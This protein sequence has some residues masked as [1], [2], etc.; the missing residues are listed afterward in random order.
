MQCYSLERFC[1]LN[2]PRLDVRSQAVADN[3]S[4]V[5]ELN[6]ATAIVFAKA[7]LKRRLDL[8]LLG[9]AFDG[10][11]RHLDDVARRRRRGLTNVE[12]L[13]E[14]GL[15]LVKGGDGGCWIDDDRGGLWLPGEFVVE[16]GRVDELD[17]DLRV[18]SEVLQVL[19]LAKQRLLDVVGRPDALSAKEG[20]ELLLRG[21]NLGEDGDD[22]A[23]RVLRLGGALDG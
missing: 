23:D 2:S 12:A 7:L 15:T 3:F 20:V 16:T 11:R 17:A 8:G 9:G 10:P 5:V 6:D 1:F 13:V 4:N 14:V 19:A 21:G 22:I 18:A